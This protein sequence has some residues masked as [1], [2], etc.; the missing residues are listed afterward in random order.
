ME[1]KRDKKMKHSRSNPEEISRRMFLEEN[2]EQASR[3]SSPL[4]FLYFYYFLSF[5]L[6]IF[7]VL[8]D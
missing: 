3:R 7:Q 4:Y 8:G 5:T 2:Q 6:D 1:D